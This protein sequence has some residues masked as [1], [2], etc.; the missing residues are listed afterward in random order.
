[1]SAHD[2]LGFNPMPY[3]VIVILL[4]IL[5]IGGGMWGCPQY[6]VWNAEMTGRAELARADQNREIAVRT[7]KAKTDAA[8]YEAQA[9]VERA[10]GVAEANKIVADSLGGPEGY[11]RWMWIN[12][13]KEGKDGNTVVYV[14]T[15]AG[16]PILE[17]DRLNKKK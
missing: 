3:V 15:E 6:S 17:A 9:E 16:L 5:S 7:A 1:M 12:A 4:I 2:E 10:R 13:M 11:L 14:P 8:R